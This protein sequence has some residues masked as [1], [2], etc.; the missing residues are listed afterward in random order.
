V[1][2][3]DPAAPEQERA[4]DDAAP[5]NPSAG[6]D[7][8]DGDD[9]DDEA[10]DDNGNDGGDDDRG[11][12]DGDDDEEEDGDDDG[13]GNAATPPPAPAPGSAAS[14]VTFTS[15]IRAILLD[16]CGRCHASG[17][18]PNFASSDAASSYD[19][20]FRQRNSIVGE[21]Q[22]GNMPA[23]T[24]NGAPGS[25]GCVSVAEFDLIRQWVAAGAPE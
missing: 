9:G 6:V 11:G 8:D 25:N 24:C 13:G 2:S 20:A 17:G 14:D 15:D 3:R 19:V 12:D 18:L 5:A 21:I 7:A 23:D 10:D 16:N 4:D 22:S 1:P